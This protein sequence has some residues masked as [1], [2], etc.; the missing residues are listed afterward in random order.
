[1]RKFRRLA[2]LVMATTLVASQAMPVLADEPDIGGTANVLD[3]SVTTVVTPTSLKIALNPNQYDITTKYVKTADTELD[4]DK[5]YYTEADGVY[6]KVAS[7]V[8]GSIGTYYEAVTS[9]SQVV[10]LNYGMANKST[11]AKDVAVDIKAS[12]TSA[13]GKT[14]ITFVDSAAKTQAKTEQNADGAEKGEL[15][16]YLALASAAAPAS[17]TTCPITANTYAKAT[18]FD[19]NATYFTKDNDGK[20]AKAATQPADETAF[21]AG[22]FYVETTTIG[23]EITATQLSDVTMTAATGTSVVA[24][25]PGTEEKAKASIAYKLNPAT[26]TVKDGETIDFT[27]TQAQ[28]AT[29]LEMSALGGVSAF[30]IT[31]AINAD[32]DW[33]TADTTTIKFTPVYTVT[34]ATDEETAVAG[35]YNQIATTPAGPSV[36]IT[37]A[38]VIN[39]TN[40]TAEKN[41]KSISL[42]GSDGTTVDY[43]TCVRDMAFVVA[44]TWT[45]EDGGFF[46]M[47]MPT[48][49]V[50]FWDGATVTATVTL[51]D[52]TTIVSKG[53]V[54]SAE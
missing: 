35:G 9:D 52:D 53:V 39:V 54:I 1:M 50:E 32:A 5:T 10:S 13:E 27:T 49:Y 14:A 23:P 41:F 28:L 4:T 47:V 51:S 44:D 24:F 6:T 29:K 40:L 34:A 43:D 8:V 19:A 25:E 16:M 2:A 18:A 38:G 22:T 42:T 11:E 21:K 33:T 7:P 36:S 17:G 12:Y 20:F 37:S 48:N 15:K 45:A 31:G 26:Y 3:Y 46:K 30:T